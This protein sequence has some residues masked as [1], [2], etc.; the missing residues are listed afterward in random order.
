MN[1]KHTPGP[2]RAKEGNVADFHCIEQIDLNGERVTDITY[3]T[4]RKGEEG[5]ANARLVASAPELLLAL[6]ELRDWYS[7]HTG[8][9]AV[10]ANA[11]IAKATGEQ[12]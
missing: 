8:L 2:W 3:L 12:P 5:R 4:L 6:I 7:E 10:S 9:P 11:A 1:T